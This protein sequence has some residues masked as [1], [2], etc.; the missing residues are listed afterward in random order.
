MHEGMKMRALPT[1]CRINNALI[2]FV[3]SC[4]DTWTQ[5][6][7][8]HPLVT[9]D[10]ALSR[11]CSC[12]FLSKNRIVTKFCRLAL[13]GPVIMPHHV[14]DVRL[15]SILPLYPYMCKLND[16]AF[17]HISLE[18]LGQ[19]CSCCFILSCLIHRLSSELACWTL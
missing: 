15:C 13:G 3:P 5:F 8:V 17:R 12:E 4:Q 1:D 6:V 14:Y 16:V 11:A 10:A 9:L 7:E 2:Q 19:T 18:L